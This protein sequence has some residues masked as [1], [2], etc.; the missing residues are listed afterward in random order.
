MKK[1]LLEKKLNDC[2]EKEI[3]VVTTYGELI[4]PIAE[5]KFLEIYSEALPEK[6]EGKISDI[7]KNI[8]RNDLDEK[9][10]AQLKAT[11]DKNKPILKSIV[12]NLMNKILKIHSET[13]KKPLPEKFSRIKFYLDVLSFRTRYF[14]FISGLIL[15]ILSLI[16]NN[17]DIQ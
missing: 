1:E 12:E 17:V 7:Q 15:F 9:F 2:L 14:L 10:D 16:L 4:K 11:L 3:E 5:Q 13:I 6:M 8:G